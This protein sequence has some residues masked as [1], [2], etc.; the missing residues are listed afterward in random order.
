MILS[1]TVMVK[2]HKINIK[3]FESLGYTIPRYKHPKQN[4]YSIKKGTTISVNV[5]DLLP[6]SHVK[7]LCKCDSCGT[8]RFLSYSKYRDICNSCYNHS[9]KNRQKFIGKN[10]PMYNSNITDEERLL[11]HNRNY[12]PGHRTWLKQIHQQKV[13]QICQ[14]T[15][16]LEAHHLNNW[17]DFKEQ[18]TNIDNGIL[19][20]HKHHKQFHNKYG[21]KN[22][23]KEMFEEFVQHLCVSSNLSK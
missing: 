4:R 13:C 16:R 23:T 5:N 17:I 20:C 7:I 22:T 19:L 21:T 12:Y 1:K 2:L 10:N 9:E 3:H 8:E 11:H 14:S 18:R 6:T 15:Y